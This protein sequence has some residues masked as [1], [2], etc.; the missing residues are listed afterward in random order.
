MTTTTTTT[1]IA[2][3]VQLT[4]NTTLPACLPAC[5]GVRYNTKTTP[6][7]HLYVLFCTCIYHMRP[8]RPLTPIREAGGG[9]GERLTIQSKIGNRE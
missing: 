3:K 5:L 1:M 7:L 8:Y 2:R 9:E 6:S 4:H